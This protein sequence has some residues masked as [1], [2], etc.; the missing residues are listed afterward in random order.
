MTLT[1]ANISTQ[2]SAAQLQ[3]AIVAIGRQVAENFQP[4]W[5]IG[6][7]LNGTTAP[8]EDQQVPI[9][10]NHNAVI[11][12]GDSSQDP[13]TGISKVFGY[14][15]VNNANIPY[16]FVYLDICEQYGEVWTCTLSHEVLELLADP[17]AAMTVT[18][19]A[20]NSA[21]GNVYY[22]LEVAD[23]TMGDTYNIDNIVVSNFV[24]RAYFG[25]SG[26]NGQTNFLN[27]PLAAFGVRPG[28]YFQYEDS[29]GAHQVQGQRVTPR[30]LAAKKLMKSGRRNER[31]IE[32]IKK[33]RETPAP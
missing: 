13:T 7:T 20:P 24:G 12:L 6:A 10:G 23:P 8:L 30:Q 16:G 26:G 33:L 5:N 25:L 31:R 28:G 2:I 19:P 9:Q 29:G 15:F 27:L 17:D 21:P 14:H 1:I 11:Y 18:G 32:R 3:A 4:E 22:D